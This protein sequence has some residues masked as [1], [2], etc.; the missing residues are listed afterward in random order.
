MKK[1]G[2]CDS[3]HL[4]ASALQ[5]LGVPSEDKI[6]GTDLHLAFNYGKYGLPDGS[7]SP[8]GPTFSMTIRPNAKG[9]LDALRK[10]VLPLI[11]RDEAKLRDIPLGFAKHTSVDAHVYSNPEGAYAIIL[12]AALFAG[13]FSANERYLQLRM[14]GQGERHGNDKEDIDS[15]ILKFPERIAMHLFGREKPK[16]ELFFMASWGMG[17]STIASW[18]WAI[19]RAQ[20]I[21]LLM[22]E[23]GHVTI[24]TGKC[25]KVR[26]GMFRH[27]FVGHS[28]EFEADRWAATHIAK[29]MDVLT[30]GHPFE[31]PR[32]VFLLFEYF[33]LLRKIS[34]YTLGD[35][36]PTPR[37][38]F[39]KIEGILNPR[40]E[41][42]TRGDLEHDRWQVDRLADAYIIRRHINN[43]YGE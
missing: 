15:L 5:E 9:I 39:A 6:D 33:E 12:P 30:E 21:F 13:L 23:F 10:T 28:E 27:R 19:T 41:L 2:S 31:I 37:E 4:L 18:I 32:G 29:G 11:P 36:N 17:D 24:S 42:I 40:E 38:R 22:H 26:R 1:I 35:E 20:Q 3:K 25:E 14:A 43:P 34:V 7:R 8:R 16:E